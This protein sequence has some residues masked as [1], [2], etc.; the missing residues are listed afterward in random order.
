MQTTEN[1]L[2]EENISSS[3]HTSPHFAFYRISNIGIPVNSN[4]TFL[5]MLGFNSFEEMMITI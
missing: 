4:Q 3:F 1:I 5:R 2:K